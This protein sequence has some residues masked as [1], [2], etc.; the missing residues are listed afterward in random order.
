MNI[1]STQW[2]PAVNVPKFNDGML[3]KLTVQRIT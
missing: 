1:V 3:K 2:L